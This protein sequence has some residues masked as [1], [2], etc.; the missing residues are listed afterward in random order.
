[1]SGPRTGVGPEP[2]DAAAF[3]RRW[4]LAAPEPDWSS[5]AAAVLHAARAARPRALRGGRELDRVERRE[6]SRCLVEAAALVLAA[7]AAREGH[8]ERPSVLR[9]EG[10]A[11]PWVERALR[12]GG[13]RPCAST[14]GRGWRARARSV[15]WLCLG[16]GGE[17]GALDLLAGLSDRPR[18]IWWSASHLLDAARHLCPGPALEHWY[19]TAL[20]W[21][22]DLER[23]RA[24]YSAAFARAG[25]ARR[26]VRALEGLARVHRASGRRRTALAAADARWHPLSL[27]SALADALS[28]GCRERARA[29]VELLRPQLASARGRRAW[30]L[31]EALRRVALIEGGE[32][33]D[34]R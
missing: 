24:V 4:S 33:R 14:A 23:A 7:G 25:G 6:V 12:D 2:G 26:D 29:L 3:E 8:C 34:G 22:G 5:G 18:R 16:R 27:S 19:A 20:E 13:R 15:L 11:P 1:M 17:D 10:D 21:E 9:I 30:R 32:G 28:L 31:T